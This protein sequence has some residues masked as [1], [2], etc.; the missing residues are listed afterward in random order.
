MF[1]CLHAPGN[2][3]AL[4]DCARYFS[5]LIEETSPDTAVFDI[6]G[7]RLI[8]GPVEQIAKEILLRVGVPANLAIAPNP[9]AAVHA[10]RGIPGLT[11]IAPGQ[12][13]SALA[14]LLLFQL[15]GS[16]EFAETLHLWG[17]RTFGEFAALPPMGVAARLGDAGL[18]LQRLA[19]GETQRLL[20]VTKDAVAYREEIEPESTLD[21]VEQVLLL[22][23]RMMNDL[24]AQLNRHSLAANEIHLRLKLERAPDYTAVLRL[25]VPMLD[26]NVF[27]KLLHLELSQRSPEAAVERIFLELKP[28][29]PRTAQ[30][31]LFIP[32]SPEPERLEITLARIRGL[33]GAGNVGAPVILD[34]H[35]P[36]S[37][38]LGSLRKLPSHASSP[39]S[40]P[41]L[42]LAVRRF[43][44]PIRAQV[45]C[46]PRGEPARIASSRWEGRVVACAGPWLTS[47]DWWAVDPWDHAQWD[48]E[49]ASG[50]L[51]LIHRNVRTRVWNI[52][53]S[54]D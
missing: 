45:W 21:L 38:E 48:V 44:P 29:E 5:P 15:S 50:D 13:A 53:S 31:G 52:D 11:I 18:A 42:R 32:A 10:A 20:R 36:D 25:P 34:T 43:R 22:A 33:V 6:R 28:V 1:A 47:G 8:Y 40:G 49:I 51:L 37:F 26:A 3:P 41:G 19:C 24:C 30:H 39:I 35:R 23:G 17:L 14:R 54:Y 9:D 7:L 4:V 27:L 46:T 16:A 2:L 12:E